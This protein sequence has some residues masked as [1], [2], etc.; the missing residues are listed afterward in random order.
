M[1][2]RYVVIVIWLVWTF[3]IGIPFARAL[4]DFFKQNP[5]LFWPK[6]ILVITT[7]F[8]ISVVLFVFQYLLAKRD[9]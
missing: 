5:E 1:N 3:G 7:F 2:P 9:R 6:G 4:Q 8:L